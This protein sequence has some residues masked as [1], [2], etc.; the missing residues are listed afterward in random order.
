MRANT[1]DS[2]PVSDYAGI[3]G[4]LAR[5]EA[6]GAPVIAQVQ[7]LGGVTFADSTAEESLSACA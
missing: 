6:L 4:A 1:F 2:R 3:E 7:S 5:L